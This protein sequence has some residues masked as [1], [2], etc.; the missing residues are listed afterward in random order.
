M[1]LK[2]QKEKKRF[3]KK[4]IITKRECYI[5]N[6]NIYCSFDIKGIIDYIEKVFEDAPEIGL[7]TIISRT[8]EKAGGHFMW[9]SFFE[10]HKKIAKF[11]DPGFE[12]YEVMNCGCSISQEY[13]ERISRLQN[14][15]EFYKET[16]KYYLEVKDSLIKHFGKYAI[17]KTFGVVN[18]YYGIKGFHRSMFFTLDK[19][20][21]LGKTL[22]KAKKEEKKLMKDL[23]KLSTDSGVGSYEL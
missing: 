12:N 1:L 15:E 10:S 2:A 8:W 9:L 17:P 21:K 3:M 5:E 16:K 14:K 4:G 6:Y 19:Q 18:P 20:S 11:T 22:M 23:K 7:E 13:S